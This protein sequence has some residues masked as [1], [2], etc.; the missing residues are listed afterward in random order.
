MNPDTA[1]EPS[2]RTFSRRQPEEDDWSVVDED[3]SSSGDDDDPVSRQ[4]TRALAEMLFSTMA[5]PRP[6]SSMGKESEQPASPIGGAPPAPPPPPPP[7]PMP[8]GSNLPAAPPPQ[9]VGDRGALLSQIS[10]G[11][12]LKKTQTKDKSIPSFGTK[13][14]DK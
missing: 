6:L 10:M 14:L 5:P 11:K 13:V 7:P 3:E 2:P 4:G 1:A 9:V 12:A 8:S